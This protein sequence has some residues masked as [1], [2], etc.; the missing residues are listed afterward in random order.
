MEIEQIYKSFDELR[1]QTVG[2]QFNNFTATEIHGYIHYA[3]KFERLIKLMQERERDN[4]QNRITPPMMFTEIPSEG[5]RL[6][7]EFN[8]LRVIE[9]CYMVFPRWVRKFIEDFRTKYKEQNY[10]NNM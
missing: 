7:A 9:E 6:E 4:I 3:S 1:D 5:S 8:R 10:G 2:K